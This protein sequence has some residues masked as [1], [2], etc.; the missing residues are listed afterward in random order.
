MMAAPF[1]IHDRF[2]MCAL[3]AAAMTMSASRQIFSGF[4]VR[5]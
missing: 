5:L 1:L 2:T 4:P 3:P